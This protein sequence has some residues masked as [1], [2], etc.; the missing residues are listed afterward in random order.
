MI[1]ATIMKYLWG[2]HAYARN[3]V[4]CSACEVSEETNVNSCNMR[5][6]MHIV[7]NNEEMGLKLRRREN[8]DSMLWFQLH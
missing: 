2:D 3:Y 5:F 4:W 1:Q 6:R 7:L 8:F